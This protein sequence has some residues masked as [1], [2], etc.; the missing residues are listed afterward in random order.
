MPP[1]A[2]YVGSG[3]SPFKRAGK[4]GVSYPRFA[5]EGCKTQFEKFTDLPEVPSTWQKAGPSQGHVT[6]SPT[7]LSGRW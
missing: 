6:L 1:S 3:R 5:D 4:S 2:L 7:S